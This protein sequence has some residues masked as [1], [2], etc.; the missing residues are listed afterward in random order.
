MLTFQRKGLGL[1]FVTLAL[2]GCYSND[3]N[4]AE[5]STVPIT[6]CRPPEMMKLSISTLSIEQKS[7]LC[8]IMVSSIHR[9]PPM[10]LLKDFE[11][12]V[13]LVKSTAADDN[14]KAIATQTMNIVQARQQ[15]NN[16]A[17]M[18]NTFDTIW[19]IYQN[20]QTNVTVNDLA[21]ALKRSGT[22][23][24]TLSDAALEQYGVSLWRQRGAEK[25]IFY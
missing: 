15:E 25:T 4:Q 8:V 3:K 6:S 1:L 10:Y 2:A 14:V 24:A 20:T 13:S 7:D 21:Q 9:L 17:A 22:S 23:A 12:F 18:Q 19:R 16:D 11:R 5:N